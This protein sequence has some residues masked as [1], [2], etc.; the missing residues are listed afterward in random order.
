M[1]TPDT[2]GKKKI[3]V[4]TDAQKFKVASWLQANRDRLQAQKR[5]NDQAAQDAS[6]ELGFRVNESQLVKL[7]DLCGVSWERESF[8]PDLGGTAA[9]HHH[10]KTR[11]DN[12]DMRLD[13][14][15][16]EM[17]DLQAQIDR[18]QKSVTNPGA[19]S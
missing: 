11:L 1:T 2:T 6:E 3:N 16:M 13:R 5:R 19:C 7:A 14:I 12:H 15:L 8:R 9:F 10:V 17:S 18:L 4:L